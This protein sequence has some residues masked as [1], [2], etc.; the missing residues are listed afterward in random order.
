MKFG[1]YVKQYKAISVFIEGII[2]KKLRL[3]AFF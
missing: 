3:L 2:T 1:A